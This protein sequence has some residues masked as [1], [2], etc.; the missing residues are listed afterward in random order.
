[1]VGLQDEIELFTDERVNM[2]PNLVKLYGYCCDTRLALVFD[3]E[4]TGRVLWDV[5]SSGTYYYV[6]YKVE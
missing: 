3:E 2:H 6:D 4:F 1:M 5:L